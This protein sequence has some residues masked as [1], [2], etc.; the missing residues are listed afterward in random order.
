MLKVLVASSRTVLTELYR[1]RLPR[2]LAEG[3]E[4]VSP[5]RVPEAILLREPCFVVIDTQRD[6]A[7]AVQLVNDIHH[8]LSSYPGH[9][10]DLVLFIP[11]RSFTDNMSVGAW[12]IDG[13]A[14]VSQVVAYTDG[15]EAAAVE[16]T[17]AL[18]LSRAHPTN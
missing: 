4:Q 11:D 5:W 12:M 14:A 18:L 6:V 15:R 8:A 2:P 10:P 3:V 9:F 13:V 17:V 1:R 16:D 7:R